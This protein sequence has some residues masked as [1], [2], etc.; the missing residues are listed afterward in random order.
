MITGHRSWGWR[1][2]GAQKE[3][4]QIVSSAKKQKSGQQ[5]QEKIK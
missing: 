5:E 3:E 2:W 4:R 1:G